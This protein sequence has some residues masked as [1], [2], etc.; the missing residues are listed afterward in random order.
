MPPKKAIRSSLDTTENL[1]GEGK[2]LSPLR[3]PS[4]GDVLRA[5][6]FKRVQLKTSVLE[7]AWKKIRVEVLDEVFRIWG[8]ASIP[9]VTLA[10]ARKMLDT[11]H[12]MINNLRK[13]FAQHNRSPAYKVKLANS[14]THVIGCFR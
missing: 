2:A 3:L 12:N 11:Y 9:T 8:T 10:Q 4:I 6:S 13:S 7:P 5:C 1:L 14:E